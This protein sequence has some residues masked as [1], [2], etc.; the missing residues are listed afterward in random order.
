MW[1]SCENVLNDMSS[2]PLRALAFAASAYVA[3][4]AHFRVLAAKRK[5]AAKSELAAAQAE[6][7]LDPEAIALYTSIAKHDGFSRAGVHKAFAHLAQ[8]EPA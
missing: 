8:K 1:H 3:A 7:G 5:R 6:T 4:R 2:T